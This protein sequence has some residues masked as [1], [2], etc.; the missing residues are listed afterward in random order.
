MQFGQTGPSNVN[1]ATLSAKFMGCSILGLKIPCDKESVSSWNF[2]HV[3][4]LFWIKISRHDIGQRLAAFS[5]LY[6]NINWA[7]LELTSNG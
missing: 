3:V 5:S 4:N 2:Q 7:K 6:W 1:E